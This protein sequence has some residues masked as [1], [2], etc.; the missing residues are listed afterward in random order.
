MHSGKLYEDYYLNRPVPGKVK[1]ADF[2]RDF[3]KAYRRN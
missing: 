3:A 1:M 2:A